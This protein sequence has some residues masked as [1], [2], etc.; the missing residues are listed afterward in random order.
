MTPQQIE[1][2]KDNLRRESFYI[3]SDEMLDRFIS[4]GEVVEYPDKYRYIKEGTV[5][6]NLYVVIDGLSR[7]GF[8]DYKIERTYGFSGPGTFVLSP[9]GFYN[10]QR[11]YYFCETC[12]PTQFLLLTRDQMID[13]LKESHE[14]SI[15][16]STMCLGQYQAIETKM[17]VF[18]SSPAE[19]Y[20]SLMNGEAKRVLMNLLNRPTFVKSV[21]SRVLASY[22]GI[23]PAYLSNIRKAII[24]EERQK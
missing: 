17:S 19:N 15:W 7:L 24:E 16:F 22:L 6:T 2:F 12:M 18:T 20:R 1:A 23:T 11:A 3:P 10:Q 5:N 13:F 14:F 4:L 9:R 21:T 8:N